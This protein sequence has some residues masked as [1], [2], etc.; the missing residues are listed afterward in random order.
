MPPAHDGVS[1]RQFINTTAGAAA[2]AAGLLGSPGTARAAGAN[3]RLGIGLVGAGARGRT[4]LDVL[5]RMFAAG[6]PVQPVAVCDVFDRHREEKAE[7][8]QLGYKTS[9]GR[10]VPGTG[11]RPLLS[12]DYRHIIESPDVD[13]VLISTP[14][15]WHGRIAA[16]AL[17]AGKHV[18]CERP[19]THTI[20]E[21]L[22]VLRAW[23]ESDRVMQVGVQRTSD[24][25]WRAANEFIRAGGIGKVVQAQTEYFRN[26]A[27]G[28]WRSTG[29][30]RDMTP[31]NIDWEM[32]LGSRVGLAP[33]MPFDRAKFAQWRCYWPFGSGP[34]GE[35]FVDRLTQ[36]L[37]ATG[38]RFPRRV[39][40]AGGIF[41]E[42]DGREVPDTVTLVADYD[43]GMQILVT[44]TMCC[45]HP[46]EQC[47]RGQQGT[48]VFDLGKDG[49]DVLP[50]RPQITRSADTRRRHIA[51][52]RPEDETLDHWENFVAA[53]ER[54]DPAHCHNPPDLAA[55]ATVAVL[56]GVQ[57]YREGKVLEWNGEEAVGGGDQFAQG[58]EQVSRERSAERRN[59][60][61]RQPADMNGPLAPA[62]QKLAGPWQSGDVDPAA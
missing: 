11:R 9:S 52:P 20:P 33:K 42:R 36:M 61:R 22:D 16:D 57:S 34:F 23:R 43:E 51:A 25:R 37:A 59:G 2:A 41:W 32:F 15:H 55:A 38:A 19:M 6:R 31:A 45:D 18:Y 46:I 44:A 62:Y 4:H 14:D 8:V 17:R 30:S 60:D 10:R 28:Q 5:L 24:G 40:A 3:G 50:E 27:G 58:W 35:L 53:I 47:I 1:R 12:A 26:S 21:A 56:M 49:F 39:T 13:V 54:N 29:L 48:I 7:M